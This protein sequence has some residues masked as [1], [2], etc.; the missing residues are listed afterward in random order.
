MNLLGKTYKNHTFSDT[1]ELLL[2]ISVKINWF[3]FNIHIFII[4]FMYWLLDRMEL[5]LC[6]L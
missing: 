2:E 3:F 6:N 1:Y 4:Y 5:Y